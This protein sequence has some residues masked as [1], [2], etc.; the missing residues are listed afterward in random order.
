MAN[1]AAIRKLK[2]AIYSR[3]RTVSLEHCTV[4]S[5]NNIFNAVID[6]DPRI[7][8]FVELDKLQYNYSKNSLLSLSEDYTVTIEYN[9]KYLKIDEIIVYDG[10]RKAIDIV[11][12]RLKDEICIVGRDIDSLMKG[13]DE[14]YSQY[15]D[16]K[17]G[18]KQLYWETMTYNQYTI[19]NLYVQFSVDRM[20][21]QNIQKKTEFEIN[22]IISNIKGISKVPVFLKVFLIFSY[23]TQ[24]CNFNK[25]AQLEQLQTGQKTN[26]PNASL[27]YG[28]INDRSASSLGIAWMM[29]RLLDGIGIENIIIAG[30]IEDTFL[31][32]D[33]YFW[34]M[35]KIDGL[36]YHIDASW[37]IDMDG[38]FVGG[39]MKDDGFMAYTHMWYDRYPNAKGS[40][41]D[42]DFVED[43]LVENGEDLLDMGIPDY[44]L[45]PEPVNDF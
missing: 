2:D 44:L 33:N 29:K 24:N 8:M 27:S 22:R 34:N 23:V 18:F 36:Y 17:E 28:V 5:F 15:V 3:Q 12:N 4:G 7:I 13:L 38:I 1:D 10:R 9:S 32:S 39:F 37:N 26:Y 30:K 35:V 19:L 43:Y 40:R 45:F 20:Q 11:N 25:G 41:F 21:M 31:K 16:T 6:E 42:Y 14:V